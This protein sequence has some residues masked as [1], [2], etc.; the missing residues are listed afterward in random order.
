MATVQITIPDQLVLGR[1]GAIGSLDVDWS[2]VPQPVLDHIATV[3]FPQYLTDAANAGGRAETPA[4]RLARAQKKLDNMY[5]GKFR[6]RDGAPP[7]DPIEL[8]AQSLAKA[9]LVK[10][11]KASTA[12]ASVPK[13]LRKRDKGVVHALNAV[14]ATPERTLADWIANTL[15]RKPE[16]MK[17]AARI[18]RERVGIVL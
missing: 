8:E 16:I 5:A 2:R 3:Y 1:N 11:A 18:V 4:E 7:A 6:S 9:A 14:A 10:T 17:S 12:W 13:E 15:E